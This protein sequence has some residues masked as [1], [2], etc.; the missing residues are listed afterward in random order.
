MDY[1]PVAK[2]REFPRPTTD[3]SKERAARLH[4]LVHFCTSGSIDQAE[5]SHA[6]KQ[7]V[8][9]SLKLRGTNEEGLVL[10]SETSCS[11]VVWDDPYPLFKKAGDSSDN[12]ENSVPKETTV[13]QGVDA[14]EEGRFWCFLELVY[15]QAHA[16]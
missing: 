12:L 13:P 14:A 3:I 6:F 15:Y 11:S 2:L 8:F 5:F 4:E 16:K 1:I 9:E 10:D 7:F